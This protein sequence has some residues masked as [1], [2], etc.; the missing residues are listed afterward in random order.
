[1][2]YIKYRG[3]T[4]LSTKPIS[5]RV[6]IYHIG[7]AQ[8]NNFVFG[9]LINQ[10]MEA[11]IH[12]LQT[13]H[14]IVDEKYWLINSGASFTG[15]KTYPSG[16]RLVCLRLRADFFEYLKLNQYKVNT[17]INLALERWEKRH[18]AGRVSDEELKI[19]R[20]LDG[21]SKNTH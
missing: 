11:F 16:S 6:Q 10:A 9:K 18:L 2:T 15:Y 13:G 4:G 12:D 17:A 19:L 8:I 20:R 3:K 1:M 7:Y 21:R 14:D 5:A